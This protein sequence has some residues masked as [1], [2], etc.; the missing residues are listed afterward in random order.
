MPKDTVKDPLAERIKM[1][2]GRVP[3]A[4]HREFQAQIFRA[5]ETHP[6]LTMQDALPALIRLLRDDG[7]WQKFL[8]ELEK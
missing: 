2:G 4:I 7:V 6:D 8:Q 3:A 5:Q 1:L